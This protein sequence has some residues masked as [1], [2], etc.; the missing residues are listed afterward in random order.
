M[1]QQQQ[2]HPFHA[3][4]TR[5]AQAGVGRSG[6]KGQTGFLQA[7]VELTGEEYGPGSHRV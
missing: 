4:E 6:F 2:I 1:V 7:A 3:G 5:L